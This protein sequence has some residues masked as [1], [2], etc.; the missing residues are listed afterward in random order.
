MPSNAPLRQRSR[1]PVDCR[2]SEQI[3]SKARHSYDPPDPTR[4]SFC[5]SQSKR[6]FMN[7]FYRLNVHFTLR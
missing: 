5:P 6:G 4:I 3:K 1:R 7:C 2:Y